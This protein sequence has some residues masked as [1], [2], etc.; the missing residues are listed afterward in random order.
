MVN[1]IE[2]KGPIRVQ[3]TTKD[4]V[5]YVSVVQD[6]Y[7]NGQRRVKTLRS[8]GR[9]DNESLARAYQF[10]ANCE[11]VNEL[12][13]HLNDPKTQDAIKAVFGL[14]LGIGVLK[15]LLEEV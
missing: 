14:I 15:W 6:Y 9:K 12:A 2:R 11:A 5:E 10:K 7:E 13:A 4:G 1:S 8:F 3:I